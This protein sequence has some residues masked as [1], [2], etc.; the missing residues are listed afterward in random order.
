MPATLT[1]KIKKFGFCRN[2][3]NVFIFSFLCV[4]EHYRL[5]SQSNLLHMNN[6][7][8]KKKFDSNSI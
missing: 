7:A 5:H 3:A 4:L 6:E 1:Y 2:F 8:I